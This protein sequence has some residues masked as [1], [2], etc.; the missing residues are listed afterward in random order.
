M[1]EWKK[2]TEKLIVGVFM[3]KSTV[4]IVLIF[5][6]TLFPQ[7]T[8]EIKPSVKNFFVELNKIMSHYD[9]KL[10]SQK[11][12][13]N[14][15][16]F[17]AA[18]LLY[19]AT[20]DDPIGFQ[21]QIKTEYNAWGVGRNIDPP[22]GLKPQTKLKILRKLINERIEGGLSQILEI[23]YYLRVKILDIQK[24]IYI[25][26]QDRNTFPQINLICSVEDIIKGEK[27]FKKGDRITVSFLVH[28]FQESFPSIEKGNSYFIAVD[29]WKLESE[30]EAFRL[31]MFSMEESSSL[32]LLKENKLIDPENCYMLDSTKIWEVFKN[33]FRKKYKLN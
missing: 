17:N 4:L 9:M 13:S 6:S 15:E 31:G 24:T 10:N 5:I 11:T 32:L 26:K 2:T 1:I 21:K 8:D 18:K 12:I 16:L 20:E 27:R 28:W 22:I 7:Q 33:N 3:K 25:L 23:P 30:N 14:E 19:H 29:H